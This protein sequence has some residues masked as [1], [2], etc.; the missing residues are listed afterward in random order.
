MK[1]A[2]CY[3]LI[4]ATLAL[5]GCGKKAEESS[6]IFEPAVQEQSGDAGSG[7]VADGDAQSGAGEQ[8]GDADATGA[9][10]Q[11][12][13]GEIDFSA[14][15]TADIENEVKAAAEAASTIQEEIA[16]VKKVED[17]YSELAQKAETQLEMNF[18]S[19]WFFTIWDTE[20]N[21]IWS[22]IS[23]T[24]DEQ[25]KERILADQRNWIAM[26]DEVVLENLGPEDEGGSIYPT[27]QNELL[28][29]LTYNRCNILASELAA[30]KGESFTM[31]ERSVYGT[32]V[33]NQGTD[34]VF[35]SLITR[36]GWENDDQA[37][38]SISRLATIEG[39]FTDNG[40]GELSFAT[41]DEEIKGI[42]K[43]NGWNGASFEVTECSND[44]IPVGEKFEFG[45]AF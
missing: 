9:G 35:G 14:D 41:Y 22:R 17:K 21:S 34:A 18:S 23:D 19:G 32:Y 25:T 6:S 20:L 5:A 42:I 38:I 30:I 26:K 37:V 44:M 27:L 16:N 29:E 13:T 12:E 4:F 36:V 43:L 40:N 1:K 7:E 45:F 24:A 3:V 10:E 39:E 15:L 31:P 8:A 11:G 2:I 28:K 33:D